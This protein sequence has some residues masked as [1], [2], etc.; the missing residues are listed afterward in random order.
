MLSSGSEALYRGNVATHMA[1]HRLQ[2]V[3]IRKDVA[4]VLRQGQP[5]QVAG[6]RATIKPTKHENV[7]TDD[8][9]LQSQNSYCLVLSYQFW[10]AHHTVQH[11]VGHTVRRLQCIVQWGT[12]LEDYSAVYDG[13]YSQMITMQRMMGHTVIRLQCSVQWGTQLEDYI[14]VYNGAYS[15]MITMQCMMGHTARRL[16]CSVQWDIQPDDYNAVY[17]GA[18]S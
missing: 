16:Q 1:A 18:H 3:V 5:G 6:H 7:S 11:K 13:A 12:R 17:N 4:D 10:G 8:G 15:Q 2:T 14:A 9:R